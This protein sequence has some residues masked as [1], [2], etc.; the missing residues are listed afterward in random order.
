MTDD[1]LHLSKTNF[2]RDATEYDNS[3]KYAPV[4]ARYRYVVEEALPYQFETWLDVGC[5]TGALLS[6][7]AEQ[8]K[9]AQLF[10][11]DLSEKMIKVARAKLGSKA[12]LTVSDSERL[13]FED[14]KFD[15]I[16]C[17]FSFHHYPNP[18]AVLTEMK[19][20]LSPQGKLIVA[21][22]LP[23]TPLRHIF[24]ILS[25]LREEGAV[26]FASKNLMYNLAKS[27][28]FKVT[29]WIRLDWFYYLMVEE[30]KQK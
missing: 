20:V 6:M 5:G 17:T 30:K 14:N 15:I 8:R 21:D 9:A 23:F 28:D 4:R 19:R 16:T 11:I 29:K 22:P 27:V 24:N 10:G 25:P 2:D 12:D 7:I 26:R 3:A 18:K 1:Q 13:P